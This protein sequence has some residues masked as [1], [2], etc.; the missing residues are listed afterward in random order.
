VG[1]EVGEVG[2]EAD[3]FA[4][5]FEGALDF[6]AGAFAVDGEGGLIGD[7]GEDL[8]VFVVECGGVVVILDGHDAN[9]QAANEE[10]GAEPDDGRNAGGDVLAGPLEVLDFVGGGEEGAS[11]TEDVFGDAGVIAAWR[12][13]GIDYVDVVGEGDEAG[14]LV[15]EGDVEVPGGHE[16]AD[17]FMDAL[18]EGLEVTG[19]MDGFGDL[20]EGLLDALGAG[21]VGDFA[22]ESVVGGLELGGAFCDALFELDVEGAEGL[23]GADADEF[24]GEEGGDGGDEVEMMFVEEVGFG[25]FEVDDPG[26]FA[27]DEERDGE[28]GEAEGVVDDVVGMET[29]IGNDLGTTG[30]SGGADDAMADGDGDGVDDVA[31]EGSFGAPGGALDE[32]AVGGIGQVDDAVGEAEA[33]DA[34]AGDIPDDVFFGIEFEEGRSQG[35]KDAGALFGAAGAV[36]GFASGGDVMEVEDA[37]IGAG[38]GR[39]AGGGAFEQAD[40]VVGPDEL[41]GFQREGWGTGGI[42]GIKDYRQVVSV[43]GAEEIRKGMGTETGRFE[44]EPTSEGGV[45]VAEGAVVMEDGDGVGGLFDEGAEVGNARGTCTGIA[46]AD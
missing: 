28:F 45:G 2:F 39:E 3:E 40:G 19:L 21:A 30:G 17:D 10:R 25:M 20:V 26:D 22:L 32:D 34:V 36:F 29:G 46:Q 8:F 43:G 44:V 6:L 31:T 24:V 5:L 18:V 41:E 23:F 42:E 16:G 33:T 9:G 35:L 13:R 15:L 14:S 11:G 12:R 7:E 4:F 1:D 38:A 37:M 27:T